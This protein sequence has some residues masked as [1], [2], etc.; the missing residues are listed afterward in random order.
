MKQKE[1]NSDNILELAD[2]IQK[3]IEDKREPNRIITAISRR[4]L[5]QIT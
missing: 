2:E 5:T 3:F 4:Y 1:S